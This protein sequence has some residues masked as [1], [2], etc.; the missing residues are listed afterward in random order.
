MFGSPWRAEALDPMKTIPWYAGY[1]GPAPLDCDA[2]EL[3]MLA[4]ALRAGLAS[5]GVR[6][7]AMQSRVIFAEEFNDLVELHGSK[8][9][10][11][12]HETLGLAARVIGIA[13]DGPDLGHLRQ[14]R[15]AEPLRA[16]A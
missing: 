3:F 12:S 11:L 5:A 2:D 13:A 6:L 9:E 16:A 4:D 15:R 1:K 7:V 8:G 10:A 14:A